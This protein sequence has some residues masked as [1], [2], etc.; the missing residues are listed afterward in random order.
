MNQFTK[1]IVRAVE[2]SPGKIVYQYAMNGDVLAMRHDDIHAW[3]NFPSMASGVRASLAIDAMS[4]EQAKADDNK[5]TMDPLEGSV[6]VPLKRL[7]EL[8]AGESDS[9]AKV[10]A[11]AVSEFKG[12]SNAGKTGK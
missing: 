1:C 3:E 2:V 8:E 4:L 11:K 5:Q 10:P 7:V 6:A 9:G 12:R